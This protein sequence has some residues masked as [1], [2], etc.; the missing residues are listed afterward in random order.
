MWEGW[1]R[2]YGTPEILNKFPHFLDKPY[3]HLAF[4][5]SIYIREMLICALRVL[6]NNPVKENFYGKKN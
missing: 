4:S 1:V 6:I 3:F 5:Q 2:I